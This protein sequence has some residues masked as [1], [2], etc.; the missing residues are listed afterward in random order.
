MFNL[1]AS[2]ALQSADNS[3]HNCIADGEIEAPA[4]INKINNWWQ[5]IESTLVNLN[6]LLQIKHDDIPSSE[7]IP[8]VVDDSGTKNSFS[9]E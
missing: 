4:A 1:L 3:M 2:Q 5:I 7:N 6:G 8:S 9:S